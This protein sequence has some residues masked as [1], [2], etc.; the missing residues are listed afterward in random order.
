[1]TNDHVKGPG[2]VALLLTE[3]D[4]AEA[5]DFHTLFAP[6]DAVL[7]AWH[8]D[9]VRNGSRSRIMTRELGLETLS[10]I[11]GTQGY[12]GVKCY[13]V[14]G[15]GHQHLVLLFR[16]ADG[17]L[18][19]I[20]EGTWIGAARTGILSAVATQYLANQDASVLA[21]IGSG[22]QA[23]TQA[24][25]ILANRTIHEVR[26]YSRQERHRDGLAG[27]IAEDAHTP[28]RSASS[29]EAACDGADIICTATTSAAPIIQ[30]DDITDGA[31]INAI[32]SRGLMRR[33]LASDLMC[34]GNV[35]VDTRTEAPHECGDLL[36]LV[37]TGDADWTT[38]VELADVASGRHQ[39]R[40]AKSDITIFESL[41]MGLFDVVTAAHLLARAEEL[42]LGSPIETPAGA[43]MTQARH[44]IGYRRAHPC[45]G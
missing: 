27:Q 16:V 20:M 15:R 23:H 26:V 35:I 18:A 31:H 3:R 7:R 1:M 36:P 21:V 6:I 38:L 5:L 9:N 41:G 4:I 19:A 25:A 14:K 45:A 12:A 32:G 43:T 30:R 2:G 8:S 37:E 28:T 42:G 34:A 29:V 22:L 13:P 40:R 44:L 39:A 17:K 11:D 24:A 10:G 33:E